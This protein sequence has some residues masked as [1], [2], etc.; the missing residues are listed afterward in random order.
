MEIWSEWLIAIIKP[1]SWLFHARSA[2]SHYKQKMI[3]S[4]EAIR[5]IMMQ[6]LNIAKKR[7]SPL[8]ITRHFISAFGTEE[9]V[10]CRIWEELHKSGNMPKG[11]KVKHL[12]W[13]LAYFKTYSTMINLSRDFGVAE[14]TMRPWIWCF[15]EAIARM[16]HI[17]S[18]KA[19]VY[20][21]YNFIFYLSNVI[22]FI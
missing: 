22:L 14:C 7:W 19:T 11:G 5:F 1:A 17:V 18:L 10:V 3:Y 12:L 15:A 4:K 9:V 20:S 21:I 8:S 6:E 2:F 16:D 13:M